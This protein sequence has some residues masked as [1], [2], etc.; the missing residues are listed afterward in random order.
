M[1]TPYDDDLALALALADLADSITLPPYRDRSFTVRHKDD[2]SE[3]TEA[4]RGAEAALRSRLGRDRPDHAVLGEERG[5]TGP[6]GATSR[7]IIDPIDGTSN[8]VKGL[9]IWATLIALE[10]GG[11]PVIGVC[12]APALG[13]RWWA[14]RGGGAFV[15]G[16][17][18]HV[19]AVASLAEAHLGYSDIGD[20]SVRTWP[21]REAA[22]RPPQG[23]YRLGG[24]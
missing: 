13:R 5:L 11:E 4:D 19:S 12:S 18:I 14:V 3:V 21:L 10:R 17:P 7:W 8:F 23:F 22:N 9:P 1:P 20:G 6:A 15:D 16:R 24:L 2:R